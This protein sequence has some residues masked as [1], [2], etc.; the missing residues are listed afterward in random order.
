MSIVYC[1]SLNPAVHPFGSYP[2]LLFI[3]KHLSNQRSMGDGNA[4]R[5]ISR[6]TRGGGQHAAKTL[7]TLP[8][9][10]EMIQQSGE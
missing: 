2:T 4:T 9:Y 6:V 10:A 3:L 5:L 1:A 8:K 7:S